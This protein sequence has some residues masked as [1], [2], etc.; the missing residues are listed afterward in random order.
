MRDDNNERVRVSPLSFQET[1][2]MERPLP[3][4]LPQLHRDHS[5]MDTTRL[6]SAKC[7]LKTVQMTNDSYQ[8]A[9]TVKLMQPEAQD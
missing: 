1:L 3:L 5:T 7:R 6:F 2:P 4:P 9:P 8:G